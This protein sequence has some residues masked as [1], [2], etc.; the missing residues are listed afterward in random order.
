MAT[1][2]LPTVV[3]AGYGG[4]I[5][6]VTWAKISPHLGAEYGVIGEGDWRVTSDT[7]GTYRVK[8]APGTAFGM[9]VF[10]TLGIEVTHTFDTIASGTRWDVLY[11]RRT[12]SGAGGTTTLFSAPATA[13]GE[14]PGTRQHNPGV[15]DEQPIALVQLTFGQTAPTQVVDLRLWQANGGATAVSEKVLQ[16]LSI[17]GTEV[18]IGSDHWNRQVNGSGV[19]YWTRTPTAAL[20]LLAVGGTA[21]GGSP[22]AGAD[23]KMQIGHGVYQSD[24]LGYIRVTLP[25]AFGT[26]MVGALPLLTDAMTH[27]LGRLQVGYQAGPAHS[28]SD[29][30]ARYLDGAGN[31]VAGGLVRMTWLAVGW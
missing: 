22:P 6:E 19:A 30:V 9:G 5:D 11:V 14:L 25:T 20:P 18:R 28:R 31:V 8:V 15:L 27:P 26:G 10:D 2:S 21:A 13:G 4:E 24:N 7:S 29:F 12:W 3:S 23:F 17:P 1:T 16:Y